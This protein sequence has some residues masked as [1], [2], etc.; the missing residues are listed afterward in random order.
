MF[1]CRNGVEVNSKNID[2]TRYSKQNF[3]FKVFQRTN[4]YN[5]LG[6]VKF[7]FDNP[8][9]VYLH[10]TPTKHLFNKSTRTFSH[11]CIRVQY[12]MQLAHVV[13]KE[14]DQ[15]KTS[16]AYYLKKGY[17]EKVYLKKPIPIHV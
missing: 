4:P 7:M 17:P 11:G 15:H 12:A 6:R 10:D 8:Y 9:S 5:A 13:L 14:I 3:P 16:L 1:I 2:F